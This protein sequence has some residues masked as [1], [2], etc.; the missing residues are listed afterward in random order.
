MKA[1]RLNQKS[2]ENLNDF[3][4]D[5]KTE[6]R[7]VLSLSRSCDSLWFLGLVTELC[8]STVKS[9]DPPKVILLE[10]Q[11][12]VLFCSFANQKLYERSHL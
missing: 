3:L 11:E 10:T 12:K 6:Q 1:A 9:T 8:R 5:I 4:T 2:E 7:R